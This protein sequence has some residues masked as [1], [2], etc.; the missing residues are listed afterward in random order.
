VWVEDAAIL[1]CFLLGLQ[2]DHV[3]GGEREEGGERYACT[4]A[5]AR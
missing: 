4:A 2:A 1:R 3:G 5:E